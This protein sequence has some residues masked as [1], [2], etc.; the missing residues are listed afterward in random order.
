MHV[1]RYVQTVQSEA[2]FGVAET[3]HYPAIKALF[4]GVGDEMKP[5]V[6][7]VIHPRGSGAGIPDGAVWSAKE[8]KKPDPSGKDPFDLKRI[9]PDRGGLE[10]KG[11]DQDLH[12]LVKTVQ[13][14]KYLNALQQVIVTNLRQFAVVQLRKGEPVI[15]EEYSLAS[16]KAEFLKLSASQV[17][18]HEKPLTEFLRRAL[19]AKTEIRTPAELA[20]FLASHAKAA[21]DT[22]DSHETLDDL[23]SLKHG[24]ERSLGIQFTGEKGETFF[25]A[26]LIQ[27]LFY[28][29]FSSWVLWHE[30]NPAKGQEFNFW[31]A[32]Q[33]LRIPVIDRLFSTAA[34]ATLLKR[35]GLDHHLKNA[36]EALNRVNREEFFAAFH[37]GQAVQYF[38][39][40]FLAAFDPDLRK[41]LGVWYTPPEIV[42]GMVAKCDRLLMSDLDEPDG[43]AGERVLL[44]DPCCGTGAY[45]VEALRVAAERWKARGEPYADKLRKAAT[46]RMF[47]F[48]LL[49]GPFVVAH[50]Q[51][52]FLLAQHKTYLAD[53]ERAGIYLT[54]AL[55]GWEPASAEKRM[56][57][58]LNLQAESDR[59]HEVKADKD[60]L[61]VIGNPPYSGYAGIANIQEERDLSERFRPEKSRGQG[62]NDLYVRFFAMADRRIEKTGRGLVCLISNYSWLDGLSFEKMRQT[63]LNTY[64]RIE[65]DNLH[66]DRIIGEYNPEGLTSETVF[67]MPGQSAGIKV[68]VAVTTLLKSTQDDCSLLYRDFHDA[69]ALE[70]R[71]SFLEA[72]SEYAVLESST[73]LGLP[74]RPRKANANFYS[75][76]SLIQLLP[77]NSPGV[78]TTRDDLLIDIDE[79]RLSERIQAYFDPTVSAELL[80]KLAPSAL[81]S[82]PTFDAPQVRKVLASRGM[83]PDGFRRHAYRPF[84]VRY[85]YYES[86]TNLIDRKRADYVA[87]VFHKNY[88][89]CLAADNR[90]GF[91]PPQVT[92]LIGARHLLERGANFFPLYTVT[93][94]SWPQVQPSLLDQEVPSEV[95]ARLPNLSTLASNVLI[96]TGLVG[97]PE[98]IFFHALAILHAPSYLSA[99]ADALKQDWP[100]VP[101]QVA[102]G[103][104]VDDS[105][106]WLIAG[107]ILGRKVAALLDIESSVAGIETGDPRPDLRHIAV[108][109]WTGPGAQGRENTGDYDLAAG[110]GYR[111]Q[112]GVVM[113]GNGKT[114]PNGEGR[115]VI[116]NEHSRWTNIPDEVWN[117]HLG[118]YQVLKKWLSYREAKVLGRPLK[119]EE[120]RT[121]T[122]IARRI[123]ALIALGPELDAH[124]RRALEP[125]T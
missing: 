66:G 110:W 25:R 96:K 10:A 2:Q 80:K 123:A 71:K 41:Q 116:I 93:G 38:Y 115:D 118:G 94:D 92:D 101:L 72:T 67:A 14:G 42:Q 29:L 107:K 11:L 97:Q 75:W 17:K 68:G 32:S 39:E 56:L 18:A 34:N 88:S 95:P 50:M 125:A 33:F 20:Y 60:I 114:E 5:K 4:N 8:L 119:L 84:D 120:V 79:R 44:L 22:L 49:T 55:T 89:M 9:Y 62:L 69:K 61:V 35:T 98:I 40:P 36:E 87:Q 109:R 45:V 105:R 74:F 53:G 51:V 77:F 19:Y 122:Y 124:Y 3:T 113:P 91:D 112:G 7:V 82:T 81:V 104:E 83:N 64:S 16:S 111:G 117:Y 26:E 27:T 102:G 47:G 21:K 65:I 57:D 70:R 31:G 99:N 86:E 37:E 12:Q 85:L 73:V 90:R 54:N 46:Q 15:I 63:F 100:R 58:P 121:F 23:A 52:A 28:G 6:Q 24:L 103:G 13:V 30:S 108:Y 48:E 78:Q 1:Q 106:A 76:P 43:L 59:A